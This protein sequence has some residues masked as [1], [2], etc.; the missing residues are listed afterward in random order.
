MPV[1]AYRLTFGPQAPPSLIAKRRRLLPDLKAESDY[2]STQGR[3]VNGQ[4]MERG[5]GG[6]CSRS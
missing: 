5:K 4:L 6:L 1:C 3:K 2:Q